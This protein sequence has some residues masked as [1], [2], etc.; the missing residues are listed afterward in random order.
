[1]ND[2]GSVNGF[3]VRWVDFM[4][5]R[6]YEIAIVFL[7]AAGLWL[8]MARKASAF[9][10]YGLFMLVLIKA[11][12]P[13]N[14]P[15]P[16]LLNEIPISS[17]RFSTP[18]RDW[19][20]RPVFPLMPHEL[21]Y[22]GESMETGG[23][24][25]AAEM[26]SAPITHESA[27]S[28]QRHESR[29][30]FSAL[31]MLLWTAVVCFLL[32]RFIRSQWLSYRFILRAKQGAPVDF[33]FDLDTL[34]QQIGLRRHIQVASCD[35]V[36]IP[37]V[38]G[39]FRPH[40]IVPQD[41]SSKFSEKQARWIVLHELA[42]IKRHDALI[43]VLQKLA[44]IVYFFHPAVWIANG[45]INRHKEYICDD[46]AM[47]ASQTPR[48]DCGQSIL[49]L[50][51]QVNRHLVVEAGLLGGCRSSSFIRRRLM[52]ILDE[53][54]VLRVKHSLGI[55][56]V[57]TLAACITLPSVRAK[58]GSIAAPSVD[59]T[60]PN[61][62]T[63]SPDEASTEQAS[64]AESDT[65][66][67]RIAARSQARLR[68][69]QEQEVGG[70]KRLSPDGLK[71]VYPAG[72]RT[73]YPRLNLQT[74][75]VCDLSTGV[76]QKYDQPV[77]GA[78]SPVWSPDGKRIA[79]LDVRGMTS[80]RGQSSN[81]WSTQ[82]VSILTLESGVVEETDIRGLP[83]DWSGDGRFLL[84][85]EMKDDV[86]DEE[87]SDGIRLVDLKTEES[88][89]RPFKFDWW[90]VPRLSPDG[91]YVLYNAPVKEGE[92]EIYH[93][94]VQ[95]MDSDEPI[96]ITS[97]KFGG[98]NPLWSADGKQIL[99]MSNGDLERND[100][101]SIAF[102]NGKPQGERETVVSDMGK[103]LTLNSCSNAG[104][105]LFSEGGGFP[106]QVFSANIDPDSGSVLGEP[107]QLTDREF[108]ATWPVW[109]RNG[110][111]IAY[112]EDTESEELRLCIVNSDGSDK[113]TL[114][115]VKAWTGRGRTIA[116]WHPDNEHILYPVKEAHPEKPGETLLGIYSISIRTLER[117]LIYQDPNFTKTM[118]LSPDGKHLALI[119]SGQKRQLCI[120]DTNGQN[121]RQLVKAD[122]MGWPI[123]TP[124][125]KEIIYGSPVSAEGKEDR[126]R[127]MAVST[128]G[129]EPREIYAN[130]DPNAGFY[131]PYSSWLKDG[132]YV[133]RIHGEGYRGQ[134]AI[135]LDGKSEPVRVSDYAGEG[136]SVSPD[137]TRAA[138]HQRI[139]A[140]KLWLMSDFLPDE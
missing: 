79:F 134:Y 16:A 33:S 129:G 93:I 138:W 113:R 52:R 80:L 20:M 115:S 71:M 18:M 13:F 107:A 39:I 89:V 47:A 27:T 57:L 78:F 48:M 49:S 51:K 14:I 124:D 126:K 75:V 117:R 35:S 19:G 4:A 6:S 44:Q 88:V 24:E 12:L 101:F 100:L 67:G 125:G 136:Y 61:K 65:S 26:P 28:A 73:G 56:F 30:S 103:N 84:V 46:I 127:I 118:H 116:E 70:N 108:Q 112:Y 90:V 21:A 64:S 5:G 60:S 29:M 1:M 132:R 9:L 58:D 38:W 23:L 133:F 69:V 22:A 40:L 105:L 68:L 122:R 83:C 140:S 110:Q 135:E 96:R 31:F 77:F 139:K 34:K 62:K 42:H 8:L 74:I 92:K 114:G 85:L 94:Y 109:S 15:S 45:A 91:S 17:H 98:W 97:H 66:S 119:R 81:P 59:A 11:V 50:T 106:N 2:F 53:K 10:G 121:R 32:I 95:P 87:K 25:N 54:R 41:F 37:F 7:I 86:M 63:I 3:A 36:S 120:V 137:G 128:A 111:Y 104:T 131:T 82:T 130:E 43:S 99:F 72:K 102:H 55:V 123:F 76:E